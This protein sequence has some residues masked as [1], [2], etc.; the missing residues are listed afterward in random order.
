[1]SFFKSVTVPEPFLKTVMSAEVSRRLRIFDIKSGST[2]GGP[3]EMEEAVKVSFYK[4]DFSFF[5]SHFVN[6]QEH[7]LTTS[8]RA[9]G[10][11]RTIFQDLLKYLADQN[12]VQ[13]PLKCKRRKI[14]VKF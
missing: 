2:G 9:Y 4:K 1:M 5:S 10:G 13:Q 7:Y 12:L 3:P 8:F 6:Y 14:K 11:L